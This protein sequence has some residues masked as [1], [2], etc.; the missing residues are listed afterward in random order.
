MSKGADAHWRHTTLYHVTH[1][2]PPQ[3]TC[4][5][6]PPSSVRAPRP[7]TT[8]ANVE[9]QINAIPSRAKRTTR[10]LNVPKS[11]R[12]PSPR[13]GFEPYQLA[14]KPSGKIAISPASEFSGSCP[15]ALPS[16]L[17]KERS[18]PTPPPANPPWAR[19][20]K[21]HDPSPAKGACHGLPPPERAPRISIVNTRAAQRQPEGSVIASHAPSL[22]AL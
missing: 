7:R 10:G 14:R 15:A 9:N 20:E 22:H 1:R 11:P 6:P 19:V 3:A 21:P 13:I 12:R 8:R 4:D 2:G 5:Q 17:R 18:P 16:F